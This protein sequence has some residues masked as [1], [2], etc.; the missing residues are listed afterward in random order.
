MELSFVLINGALFLLLFG[1]SERAE[2]D[3]TPEQVT[4]LAHRLAP[5]DARKL[6]KELQQ[7]VLLDSLKVSKPEPL[8]DP[9]GGIERRKRPRVQGPV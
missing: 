6:A 9:P 5:D 8:A 3:L 1:E 2:Q 7:Q 4:A